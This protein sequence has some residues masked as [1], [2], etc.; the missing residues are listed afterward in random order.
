MGRNGGRL[1]RNM[2]KGHMDKDGG[3]QREGPNVEDGGG[4]DMESNGRKK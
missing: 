3:E 4:E 1:V 2:Y